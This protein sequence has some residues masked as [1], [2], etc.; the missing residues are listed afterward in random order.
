MTDI[1]K[2]VIKQLRDRDYKYAINKP[3]LWER[4]SEKW[5]VYVSVNFSQFQLTEKFQSI[6]GC[7]LTVPLQ[8][9]E[10]ENIFCKSSF[11]KYIFDGLLPPTIHFW[12]FREKMEECNVMVI[13]MGKNSDAVFEND[14]FSD[15]KAQLHLNFQKR[16]IS[17]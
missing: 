11:H 5:N 10:Y 16:Y 3:D 4:I 15:S 14:Y 17:Y 2:E 8:E 9:L 6:L 13:E 12:I 7:A 1:E